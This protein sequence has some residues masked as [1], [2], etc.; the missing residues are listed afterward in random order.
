VSSEATEQEVYAQIEKHEGNNEPFLMAMENSYWAPT[1]I[2][3][4]EAGKIASVRNNED[5]IE[6]RLPARREL[7]AT[8]SRRPAIEGSW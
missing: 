7:L 5:R 4:I 8:E 1:V 3:M 6:C 2:R